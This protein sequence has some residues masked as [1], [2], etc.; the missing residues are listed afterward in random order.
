MSPTDTDRFSVM[1]IF[2]WLRLQASKNFK[3]L[4]VSYFGMYYGSHIRLTTGG[5]KLRT[6]YVLCRYLIHQHCVKVSVFGVFMIHIVFYSDH[7]NSEYERFSRSAGHKAKDVRIS[8]QP[9]V[10]DIC[11]SKYNS[12]T[13][14]SN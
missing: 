8:N 1:T 10:T 9:V 3:I 12:S 4:M 11:D 6:S 7:K 5:F 13:T 2:P 14:P